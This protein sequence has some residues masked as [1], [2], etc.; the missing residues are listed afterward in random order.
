MATILLAEPSAPVA[1]TLRRFLEGAGHEVAWVG[2]AAE[3]RR[4]LQDRPP[5]VLVASASLPVDGEALCQEL[6][7]KG[8]RLPV[9]LVYP[10]D[11]ERAD[12]RAAGAGAEGCLVGPLKRGTV[13][14]CVSLVLRL[15]EAGARAL[16]PDANAPP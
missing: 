4:L 5:G 12:T 11:E 13:V 15:A 3:A 14:T 9:L 7:Q 6:R 2:G 10:P 16:A 1:S 8:S